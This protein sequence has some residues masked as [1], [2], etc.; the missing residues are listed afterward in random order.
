M[1][2][3]MANEAISHAN[4]SMPVSDHHAHHESVN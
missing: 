2:V 3:S 1:T 4:A